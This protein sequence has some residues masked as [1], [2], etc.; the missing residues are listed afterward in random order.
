MPYIILVS[1]NEE[2]WAVV[3]GSGIGRAE[4]HGPFADSGSACAS[5]EKYYKDAVLCSVLRP[6]L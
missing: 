1:Q 5:V 4:P 3:F 2:Y 6:V